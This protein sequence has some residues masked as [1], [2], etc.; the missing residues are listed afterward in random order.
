MVDI[1]TKYDN[2]VL[3]DGNCKNHPIIQQVIYF[4]IS[5][6]RRLEKYK[7]LLIYFKNTEVSKNIIK[8]IMAVA[9][10]DV[11]NTLAPPDPLLRK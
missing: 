5:N 10:P 3:V 7:Q 8:V 4:M 9:P 6:Y 1:Y 2:V 11:I